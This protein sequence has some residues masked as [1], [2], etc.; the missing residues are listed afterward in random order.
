MNEDLFLL[1]LATNISPKFPI[2][3]AFFAI[4]RGIPY[5][6]RRETGETRGFPDCNNLSI[7]NILTHQIGPSNVDTQKRRSA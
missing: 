6:Y 7:S 5:V 1:D 4:F 3:F 2:F